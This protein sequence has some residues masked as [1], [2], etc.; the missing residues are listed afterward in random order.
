MLRSCK[1]CGRIHDSKYQ[2]SSRPVR[3]KIRTKQNSFRSTEAWKRKSL[4]IRERDRYLC[5][6]CIRKLYGTTQQYNNREIEVHHMRKAGRFYNPQVPELGIMGHDGRVKIGSGI[7]NKS[8]YSVSSNL[9]VEDGINHLE[10][11]DKVLLMKMKD[12][13][14]FVLIAKVVDPV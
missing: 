2:C 9:A 6:I 13:E 5:Q 1:Y 4:E 8:D 12:T 3:R 11:G 10:E 7:I 14:E